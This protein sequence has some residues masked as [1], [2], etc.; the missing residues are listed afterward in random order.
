[1]LKAAKELLGG[2]YHPVIHKIRRANKR[3]NFRKDLKKKIALGKIVS[4]N[5][6]RRNR[7]YLDVTNVFFNDLGTGIQRV[8]KELSKELK[9]LPCEYEVADVFFDGEWYF[10]CNDKTPIDFCEGDIFFEL[11]QPLEVIFTCKNLYLS[12]MKNGVKVASFF[13]DLIPVTYPKMCNPS[14][15]KDFKK[16]LKNLLLFNL[17]ICNS[18]ATADELESY[19]ESN[20]K[21]KRNPELKISYSLLGGNFHPKNQKESAAKVRKTGGVIF[22]MVSTVEP[23]KMY[24]QA[25]EAFNLLWKKN[26]D[27]NLWI[28]GRPGWENEKTIYL[29][30]NSPELGKRLLWYKNGISDVE[31]CALYEKCDAVLFASLAEGFGLAVAEGASFGKPL[32]LRDIP[33][34]REIAG[35]NAFYFSGTKPEE[36]SQKLEE[37]LSLYKNGEEPDS[38]NIKLRTWRD[39]ASDVL[40][41]LTA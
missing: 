37:W 28:A 15:V 22:L 36:L 38:K 27:V 6:I 29:I 23:R 26:L 9:T 8:A 2:I 4:K 10:F 3:R 17:I 32:I 25:V 11:D 1:M 20:P 30:E 24:A 41:T 18:K 35:D 14:Y 5:K 16:L 13:H 33:V 39:C 34:F 19:L 31:L 40:E 21:T 12:L 7:I